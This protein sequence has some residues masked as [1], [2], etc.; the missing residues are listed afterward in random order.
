MPRFVPRCRVDRIRLAKGE[1]ELW[2][3]C[4]LNSIMVLKYDR[5]FKCKTFFD[6]NSYPW[7]ARTREM[8]L[9][10][11]AS[12]LYSD[13]GP[14]HVAKLRSSEDAADRDHL[15]RRVGQWKSSE[16]G[17]DLAH[18]NVRFISAMVGDGIFGHNNQLGL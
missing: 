2:L 7:V 5:G 4:F 13:V 6:G 8:P 12:R 18:L 14:C 11:P 16:W 17:P 3:C 10:S 9:L 15:T 1:G